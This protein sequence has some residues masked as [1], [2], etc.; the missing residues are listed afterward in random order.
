MER[1]V[2]FR[3]ISRSHSERRGNVIRLRMWA[4]KYSQKRFPSRPIAKKPPASFFRS[5]WGGETGPEPGSNCGKRTPSSQYNITCGYQ[6]LVTRILT[7]AYKQINTGWTD[8]PV[9]RS[10]GLIGVRSAAR[11]AQL[12]DDSWCRPQNDGATQSVPSGYGT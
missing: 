8:R 6:M 9:I 11:H 3:R 10:T 2:G 5:Q 7:I 1:L 4:V 12:R